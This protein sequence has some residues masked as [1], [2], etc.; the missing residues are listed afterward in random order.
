MDFRSHAKEEFMK[1]EKIEIF[2]YIRKQLEETARGWQASDAVFLANAMIELL[3][4][5]L[6]H[7]KSDGLRLKLLEKVLNYKK[8]IFSEARDEGEI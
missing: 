2:T 6:Q 7:P 3:C 5:E 1:T 4:E 8:Q